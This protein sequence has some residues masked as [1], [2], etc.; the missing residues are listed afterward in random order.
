MGDWVCRSV[1][2]SARVQ[3][4]K[5][6]SRGCS[7][8][9]ELP[10]PPLFL[11]VVDPL[12]QLRLFFGVQEVLVQLQA[13]QDVHLEGQRQ[14]SASQLLLAP[15]TAT[16][17]HLLE[18]NANPSYKKLLGALLLPDYLG[19]ALNLLFAASQGDCE[20]KRCRNKFALICRELMECPGLV[21]MSS[22]GK[23][24]ACCTCCSL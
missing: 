9:H 2:K 24:Q 22:I 3:G 21:S 17:S 12:D 4:F 1:L 10:G 5:L 18:Y 16:T 11:E 15:C 19:S 14:Q 23:L 13:L 20:S 6:R 7:L 8:T